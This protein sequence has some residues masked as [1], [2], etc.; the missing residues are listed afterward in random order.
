MITSDRA[1]LSIYS[2]THPASA[3]SAVLG[4]EPSLTFEKGDP[5]GRGRV[6]PTSGWVLQAPHDDAGD[7][8]LEVLVRLLRG[9]GP[10]LAALREHYDTQIGWSGFSDDW[11]AGFHFPA[12]TLAEL[13]AL[14]CGLFGRVVLEERDPEGDGPAR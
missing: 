10:A 6:R 1:S 11:Q 7:S 9:T 8:Q 2:E 4:L 12:E 13:G 5:A 3:V 14:G